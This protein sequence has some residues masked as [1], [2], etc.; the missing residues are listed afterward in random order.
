MCVRFNVIKEAIYKYIYIVIDIIDILD[1]KYIV[2]TK[3]IVK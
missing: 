1:T 3:Y 2:T